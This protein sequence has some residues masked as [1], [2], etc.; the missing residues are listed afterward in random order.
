MKRT[1]EAIQREWVR[2]VKHLSRYRYRNANGGSNIREI[3]R[4]LGVLKG[5]RIM[6]KARVIWSNKANEG[7]FNAQGVYMGWV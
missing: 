1:N 4:Y 6:S 5:L 2:T 7:I 3:G